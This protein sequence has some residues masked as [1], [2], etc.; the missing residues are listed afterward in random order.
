M[1]FSCDWFVIL[2]FFGML[3][4]FSIILVILG[5]ELVNCFVVLIIVC[6]VMLW[7]VV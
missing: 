5:F 7:K 3:F 2:L 6:S 1:I 4:G